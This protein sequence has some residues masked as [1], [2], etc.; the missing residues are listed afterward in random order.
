MLDL[1]AFMDEVVEVI[2]KDDAKGYLDMIALPYQVITAASTRTFLRKAD[3][4]DHFH[5][6]RIGLK[7]MGFQDLSH[8]VISVTMLGETLATGIYETRLLREDRRLVA[9]YR[10]CITVRRDTGR[11]RAVCMAHTIGHADWVERMEAITAQPAY[12]H[13]TVAEEHPIRRTN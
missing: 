11:W 6:F 13:G 1:Q 2:R 3:M 5:L 8:H 12:T 9:P 7:Q 4:E 10:S